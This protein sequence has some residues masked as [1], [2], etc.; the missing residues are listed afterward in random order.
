MWIEADGKRIL[1][2]T[3]QGALEFNAR[4]RGV[5][6]GETDALVLSHGHYDHTGGIPAFLSF[7]IAAVPS[8]RR[9]RRFREI[10][11]HLPHDPDRGRIVKFAPA[12][13]QESVSRHID[14]GIGRTGALRRVSDRFPPVRAD[15]LFCRGRHAN[16]V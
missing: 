12:R 5:D 2:D 1:F 10:A 13:L 9:R 14:L 16:H 11:S 6:L 8:G 7:S 4:V 3:G 15:T